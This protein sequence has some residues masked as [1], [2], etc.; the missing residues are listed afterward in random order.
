MASSKTPSDPNVESK[1]GKWEP[2]DERFNGDEQSI[3][4]DTTFL[5]TKTDDAAGLF[6][7]CKVLGGATVKYMVVLTFRCYR[8]G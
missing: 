8:R 1:M 4:I 7:K 3:Y 6:E 2:K 5:S